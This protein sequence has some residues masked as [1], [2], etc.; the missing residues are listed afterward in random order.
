MVDP[1]HGV[2]PATEGGCMQLVS[3]RLQRSSTQGSDLRGLA[4]PLISA[5]QESAASSDPS[6][7][8]LGKLNRHG[9]YDCSRQAST[10][11]LF[12]QHGDGDMKVLYGIDFRVVC[13]FQPSTLQDRGS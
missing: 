1:Q 10:S 5:L 2:Q 7:K 4:E 12:F 11:A 3:G 8:R 6:V 9:V 13:A